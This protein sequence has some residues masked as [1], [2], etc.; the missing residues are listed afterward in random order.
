MLEVIQHY[1]FLIL[2]FIRDHLHCGFLDSVLPFFSTLGNGGMLWLVLTLSLLLVKKHRKHGT[3]LLVGLAVGF[4]LVSLLLKPLV[5]RPRPSWLSPE[6]LLLIPN[7]SDFSFPSGHTMASFIAAFLLIKYL[8]RLGY[9]ALPVAILMAFSRLY[10]YVHFPS[11]VLFS[12][13]L[14]ALTAFCIIKAADK[15]E[16]RKQ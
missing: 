12:I 1:D 6:V 8:P 9:A 11:D 16:K 14:A 7:P 5:A 3:L 15:W 2:N 4:I 13:L 10:L